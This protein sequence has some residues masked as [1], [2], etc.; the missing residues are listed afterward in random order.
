VGAQMAERVGVEISDLWRPLFRLR[1]RWRA[2][3]CSSAGAD[4]RPRLRP[5]PFRNGKAR[6]IRNYPMQLRHDGYS[7]V[8]YHL[9][10]VDDTFNY[11][12]GP[13]ANACTAF[14]TSQPLCLND[15][16]NNTND[17]PTPGM[18]GLTGNVASSCSESNVEVQ[19]IGSRAS[20]MR[21]STIQHR[22]LVVLC[23]SSK[24]DAIAVGRSEILVCRSNDESIVP[25]RYLICDALNT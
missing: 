4:A 6:W 8:I 13:N 10:T 21:S 15:A 11:W 19:F 2:A 23:G 20:R 24:I 14:Q 1:A 12:T 17:A 22:T 18:T 25:G 7:G 3:G 16:P 5:F 9:D